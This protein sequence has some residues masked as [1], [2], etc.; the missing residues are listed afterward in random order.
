M[1]SV[2]SYLARE[3]KEGIGGEMKRFGVVWTVCLLAIV[4]MMLPFAVAAQSVDSATVAE[5]ESQDSATEC[6]E[7]GWAVVTLTDV[8]AFDS[9]TSG[10]CHYISIYGEGG[11]AAVCGTDSGDSLFNPSSGDTWI[12]CLVQAINVGTDSIDVSMFDF[13]LVTNAGRKFDAEITPL[14]NK[15]SDDMFSTQTLREG[16]S[17]QG[18]ISFVVPTTAE[19]PYTIEIDPLLNFSLSPVEPSVIVIGELNTLDELFGM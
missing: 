17:T 12:V 11:Y 5:W 15:D 8:Q 16:Q 9:N 7:I 6:D 3:D 4:G 2:S 19:L 1:I 10:R 18:L 13:S 14:V